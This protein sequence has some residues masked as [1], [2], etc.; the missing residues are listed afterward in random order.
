MWLAQIEFIGTEERARFECKACDVKLV[1]SAP[2]E[3][4]A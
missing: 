1:Y 4:E 3:R 2:R